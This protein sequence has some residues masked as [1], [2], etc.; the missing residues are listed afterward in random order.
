MDKYNKLKLIILNGKKN[1]IATNKEMTNITFLPRSLSSFC[2]YIINIPGIKISKLFSGATNLKFHDKK[3]N[4][5]LKKYN[6]EIFSSL[7]IN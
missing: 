1:K 6:N 5:Q 7:F 2:A 4:K 3:I